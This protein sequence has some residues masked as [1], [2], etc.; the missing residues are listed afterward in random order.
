MLFC[1]PTHAADHPNILLIYADDLGYGDISCNGAT[2]IQTPN[3]DRLAREGLRFTDAH[4][5]SA[6]CTPSRYA[7]LTGEYAWRKRGTGV[8]PG[9]AP[10]IIEPGRQTIATILKAAS[11]KTA[12]IGKWHLGLGKQNMDWNAD[13]SPGP[14]E[15]GFN[16]CFLMP[17]T[18]DR[19][20]TVYVENHRVLNLI[21][22]DP[23]QVNFGQPIN[24]EPTGA[25][26][27]ELLK[28]HP[29]HGHDQSI[30]NGVSRIGY[31]TGG[32]S[33]HWIDEN[34]ADDFLKSA[35]NYIAQNKTN[36]FF[37]FFSTHDIHVP[38]VVHPRFAGKSKMG[39]RGDAILQFDWSVGELLKTLDQHNL[40]QNTI[41]IFTS[42]NGPVV[43]DGY[44][45]EAKEKLGAHKPA[46]P[47]RGGKYSL[48]EAGTRVPFIV[49]WPARVKPGVSEALMNQVDFPATFAALTA[50]NF[51]PKT[52]PDSQNQLPALLGESKTG[53]A[54]SVHHAQ[55]LALRAGPWKLI[56]PRQGPKRN[57]NT[58]TETGADPRPQ[59][60]NL[61]ADPAET[62]NLADT[63]PEKVLELTALLA[64]EKSKGMPPRN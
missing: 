59:L 17:A 63:N 10:L 56:E 29:S 34:M 1:F 39:P 46:G 18:G 27:P 57:I 6:T 61:A 32:K 44:K 36:T 4:S 60:Y 40:T 16:Y 55:T 8:L 5:P 26:N 62:K 37:L 23:L 11:Y 52:S 20:P 3:I 7:M 42:D 38:R 22:T 41:V 33:A 19:V 31:Q 45:D 47:F 54:T 50:R 51:D 12:V 58:D 24:N 13:I 49:R 21:S 30:V 43:D 48:F 15:L 28:L 14:L 9:N 25:K 53:R 64:A 2:Q 35:T